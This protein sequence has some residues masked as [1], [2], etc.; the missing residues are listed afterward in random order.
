MEYTRPKLKFEDLPSAAVTPDEEAAA[1]TPEERWVLET[2]KKIVAA[3][4]DARLGPGQ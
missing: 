3:F 1:T 4:P 2:R